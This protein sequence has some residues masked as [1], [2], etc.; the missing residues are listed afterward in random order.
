MNAAKTPKRRKKKV[1][2]FFNDSEMAIKKESSSNKILASALVGF[3]KAN[4]ALKKKV[5]DLTATNAALQQTH[6]AI[7]QIVGNFSSPIGTPERKRK[8]SPISSSSGSQFT[9][10]VKKSRKAS[11]PT[12][13]FAN[14]PVSEFVVKAQKNFIATSAGGKNIN[15]VNAVFRQ[16][17]ADKVLSREDVP[18]AS[19]AWNKNF[20]KEKQF[21]GNKNQL[22]SLEM[23]KLAFTH[24]Q[25]GEG[26]QWLLQHTL[27]PKSKRNTLTTAYKT[28]IQ[29]KQESFNELYAEVN[30]FVANEWRSG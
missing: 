27:V 20:L 17:I 6:D 5:K 22:K 8:G 9:P 13:D 25:D 21:P 1:L 24:Y 16:L 15:M 29:A 18:S 7:Q 23:D 4:L 3:M 14:Y 10:P 28:Y 11:S 26:E 12:M 19:Y 30:K 2:A